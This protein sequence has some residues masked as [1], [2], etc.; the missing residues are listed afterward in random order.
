MNVLFPAESEEP[1]ST[2]I[3]KMDVLLEEIQKVLAEIR[4]SLERSHS[5]EERVTELEKTVARLQSVTMDLRNPGSVNPGMDRITP[6][7]LK[8]NTLC[9]ITEEQKALL[10]QLVETH[11]KNIQE[12]RKEIHQRE[13]VE[14]PVFQEIDEIVRRH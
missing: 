11:G 10:D 6:L 3:D 1:V 14:E 8:I 4:S 13:S 2:R 5:V 7:E 12:L 9:T